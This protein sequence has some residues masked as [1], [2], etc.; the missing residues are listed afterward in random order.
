MKTDKSTCQYKPKV[1][2][3][4]F[5]QLYYC[6]WFNT[7]KTRMEWWAVKERPDRVIIFG[8][9]GAIYLKRVVVHSPKIVINLPMAFDKDIGSAVIEILWYR[10]TD[11]N[12]HTDIVLF[13]TMINIYYCC[14][15]FKHHCICYQVIK[16]SN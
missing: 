2:Q 12:K 8:C 15:T 13:H 9:G 4:N 6:S 7:S 14:T 11:T 1:I 3:F 16:E 5:Q 10:Q